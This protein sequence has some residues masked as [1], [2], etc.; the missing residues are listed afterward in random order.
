MRKTD[1]NQY[2][3]ARNKKKNG[4]AAK[5]Q[6]IG[7]IALK[8]IAT[9][10]TIFVI[11]GFIVSIALASFILSL[12]DES[13]NYD[14]HKL[15]LNYTSF[16][17]VNGPNDDSEHPVQYQSLY[18]SENRVWVDYDKIPKAMKDAIVA[19]EDKRFWDHNGVDWRRTLGAVTTLFTKGSSYGGSTITQQLIKNVTGD[20]DV[21]LTRKA[22]E[23]F[24]ALNL[25]KK[26]SKE[27][28]LASYLNIVNFG[29]GS[30]GVQA[31]ANL[32]F[33][34]D[35]QNCDIAE[36]AS[37]AG[38]TQN[39][40]AYSPLLHPAANKKRQQTVLGEMHEQG[41]INDAEYKTAMAKSENMK[42]VGKKSDNA[43]DSVP[44]WNWYVDTLF[45]DVKNGLMEYYSCSSDKAV[46][47][48]YHDGLKIY[49][50]M[51]PGLQKIAEDTLKSDT[52]F[53]SDKKLQAGYIAMD[54]SGRVL[55]TVGARGEKKGN[56]LQSF[57][58]GTQR[59]P[60]STMK[61]LAVYG[62]AI[63]SGKYTYSTLIND[64]PLPNWFGDGSP[65][66]KNWGPGNTSGKY[67]GM[68]PVEMALERS[69]NASAAQVGTALTPDVSFNFLIQKL[70][71]TSLLPADNNRAPMALGGLSVGVTVREMTAGYQMFGNGGKYYKP[72]TFYRVEDHDG[73]VILD[74]RNSAP[75]QAI[76]STTSSI[77]HRLLN[78]VITG[79][80]G[81]GRAA[82]ISGWEV[83][84][85]TGT[86]NENK[87][88]W[89]IGGTPYA[90]AGIWTGYASKPAPISN[91]TNASATWKKIMA[92]YLS[93]KKAKKFA[94]DPNVVS[95]TY[96]VA[97]GLL[98]DPGS[99]V[100]TKI[101][102]YDKNN[103]PEK[104]NEGMQSSTPSAVSSSEA[105]SAVSSDSES[106][107][108]ASSGNSSTST[109]APS[110][111]SSLPPFSSSGVSSPAQS[112]S[113]AAAHS[114]L[115][116]G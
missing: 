113:D 76:S 64:N 68:I 81:T 15:K 39:P 89:F 95:A 25:E 12:K 16:I 88:S 6:S 18:S 114:I 65:G 85:K 99:T 1:I 29:S 41:K 30:N 54:Y 23:I 104:S 57:A 22:K 2:V 19:I 55:A 13:M 4:P 96:S 40:A 66:P 48:I 90:L 9:L 102:W 7:H 105:S 44:V 49:A 108:K 3:G 27:E 37:I 31:A 45:E 42:F 98:V 38:I 35:I 87:D 59:Q 83:F 26:Y 107:G 93:D 112:K 100:E 91:T 101:G 10:F 75:V 103:M 51:D 63:E 60:G 86:T 11:T 53:G 24:R 74:N 34:K 82:A 32:Y 52:V 79:A 115:P 78:N 92:Q 97:T 71:F 61:P 62:P 21:S 109:E 84:G 14:L 72:Y 69:L 58:T 111:P 33:G 106:S 67:W 46:D 80:S 77:M 43:V 28:I 94:Y 5:I 20:K 73:N 70:K 8:G 36:C 47:M 110:T 50:A 56:R 116:V 17:Y